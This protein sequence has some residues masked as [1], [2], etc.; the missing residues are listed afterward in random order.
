MTATADSA[1]VDV[2]ELSDALSDVYD[3]ALRRFPRLTIYHTRAWSSFL[4]EA[5][6][7]RPATLVAL[8]GGDVVGV[9][10]LALVQ[11]W[12]GRRLVS[13]PYS[14]CVRA[15]GSETVVPLLLQ[16]ARERAAAEH[17]CALELR[18]AV[19]AAEWS[20]VN[21]TVAV[22]R[23]MD[24][25]RSRIDRKTRN[26]LHQAE[27]NQGLTLRDASS[28][29]DFAAMDYIMAVN[30]RQ[31]GSATYRRHFFELLK[32]WAGDV[33]KLEL[34]SLDGRP[35]AFM[36]TSCVDEL[37][38]Y[39][40]GASLPRYREVRPNNLLMWSALCWAAARGAI[41]VDL[42]TSLPSQAGLIQFKEGWGG[43]SSGLSYLTVR[44]DGSTA[45]RR[46]GQES[47]TARMAGRV[48]RHMPLPLFRRVTPLLIKEFG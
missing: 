2:V 24:A 29:S 7:A 21:T 40:Y 37:A 27:R 3:A 12:R 42:G 38:I 14:H 43:T 36:V 44:P 46:S 28:A 41:D 16:R 39:H 18:G 23:D 15:L 8:G 22:S 25:M 1:S 30:R 48:V 35:I 47:L 19:A 20:F 6:G 31:L 13:L 10:P 5:F 4:A 26:Q 9:L 34:A 33:V 32:R 45:V 11:S 17:Q